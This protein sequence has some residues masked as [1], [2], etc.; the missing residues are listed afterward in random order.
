MIEPNIDRFVAPE[1]LSRT[2]LTR[3]Y[4]RIRPFV[5]RRLDQRRKWNDQWGLYKVDR[6]TRSLADFA[7]I[8]E[9]FDAKGVSFV[10]VILRISGQPQRG[11]GIGY[12]PYT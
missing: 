7:K 3:T 4:R 8:V 1:R 12:F 6:L 11:T 5:R 10:S 2:P 9:I